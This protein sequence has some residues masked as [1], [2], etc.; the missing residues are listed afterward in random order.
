MNACV[1]LHAQDILKDVIAVFDHQDDALTAVAEELPTGNS[2]RTIEAWIKPENSEDKNVVVY[3]S[4]SCCGRHFGIRSSQ[5]TAYAFVGGAQRGF[6]NVNL[7]GWHHVAFVF[8]NNETMTDKIKAYLD[9]VEMKINHSVGAN[10]EINSQKSELSIG[11]FGF[12]GQVK[13]VR[14][15]N[16]ALPSEII[17]GNMDR[18]QINYEHPYFDHLIYQM[19]FNQQ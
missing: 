9:G 15:W 8:P 19:D 4:G 16:S 13:R 5:S 12:S 14:I 2:P 18:V 17:T 1:V 6:T 7:T 3:G 11:G 10:Y